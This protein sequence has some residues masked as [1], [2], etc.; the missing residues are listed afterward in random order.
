VRSEK[1]HCGFKRQPRSIKELHVSALQRYSHAAY[2]DGLDLQTIK[3]LASLASWGRH[4]GNVERDLH[5]MI[6][7]LFGSQFPLHSVCIDIYNPDSAKIQQIEIPI[8]LA[9][10]VIHT[11]WGKQSPKLWEIIIG[12]T[13]SKS[14]AFWNAY[15]QNSASCANHPVIQPCSSIGVRQ[16]LRRISII[17]SYVFFVLLRRF[18]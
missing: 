2:R 13:P 12:C 3:D 17:I 15:A 14:Q 1:K 11:L 6:P 9:S 5:T 4:M 16:S 7:S 8:L 10:D 18:F